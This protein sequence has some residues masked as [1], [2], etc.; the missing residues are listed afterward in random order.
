[1]LYGKP[2]YSS[3][4]LPCRSPP[5]S[6]CQDDANWSRDSPNISSI[7]THASILLSAT[8]S[9]TSTAG[10][11][12]FS[13]SRSVPEYGTFPYKTANLTGTLYVF[14]SST[15]VAAHPFHDT[16]LSHQPLTQD[17][18][19]LQDHWLAPRILY[20][21]SSQLFYECYCHFVSEDGFVKEGRSETFFPSTAREAPELRWEAVLSAYMRRK[22][23]RPED[24]LPA[25]S[26]LAR[27]YAEITG[28]AYIAGFWVKTLIGSMIWQAVGTTTPSPIYRAPSWSWASIDGPFGM[29]TP[30]FGADGKEAWSQVASILSHSISLKDESK[31]Y[32][33]ITA[34]S[35]TLRAPLELLEPAE[36]EEKEGFPNR[37]KGPRM[38]TTNG[39]GKAGAVFDTP[40]HAERARGRSLLALVLMRNMSSGCSG[41]EVC[42]PVYHCIVVAG[43]EGK[44]DGTYER[45]GKIPI[46]HEEM[47]ECAWM[48]GEEGMQD[49]VLV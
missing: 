7:Y 45:L 25:L 10:L 31:P 30:G 15:E 5:Y 49:I 33:E 20:F 42:S 36:G 29:W 8:G 12:L 26:E 18:W 28:D 11:P 6:T 17:G 1:M 21:G 24:K 47:G 39:K 3:F 46:G 32:G 27:K 16:L 34:A 43:V 44:E 40:A 14:S 19:A 9:P 48:A 23:P 4:H 38:R 35:L 22:I 37:Q 13:P 41:K 2:H